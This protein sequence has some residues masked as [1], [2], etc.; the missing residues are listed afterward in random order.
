[1]AAKTEWRQGDFLVSIARNLFQPSAINNAFASDYIYWAS[2]MEETLLE[3]MLDHSLCFGVYKVA[4]SSSDVHGQV[5]QI[6]S[7]LKLLTLG[8]DSNNLRQIG[9]AR[10]I[11]DQ[12]T[13]AYLTDVYILEQYQG[14]GLGS[15]LIGC[16]NETLLS[17]PAL[18]GTFLMTSGGDFYTKRLEMEPFDGAKI[19]IQWMVKKGP[20]YGLSD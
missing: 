12:V 1:M 15:F 17:W 5:F 10:L 2:P 7:R 16:V 3:K 18:R 9:L 19:G 11:T 4:N 20:R 13:F 8:I 6:S 14:K